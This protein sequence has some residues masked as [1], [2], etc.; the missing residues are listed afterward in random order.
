M[1]QVDRE[2][3]G[4]ILHKHNKTRFETFHAKPKPDEPKS[5][6]EGEASTNPVDELIKTVEATAVK[7]K[8]YDPFAVPTSDDK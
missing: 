8:K 3:I 1:K 5:K 2:R 4:A 6:Q 7:L